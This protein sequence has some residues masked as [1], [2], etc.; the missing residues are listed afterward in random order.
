MK[1][2]SQG[3]LVQNT[4]KLCSSGRAGTSS[5]KK[6]RTRCRTRARA[7]FR[8]SRPFVSASRRGAG[9]LLGL[10]WSNAGVRDGMFLYFAAW[11]T[12]MM[13]EKLR[14]SWRKSDLSEMTGDGEYRWKSVSLFASELVAWLIDEATHATRAHH[15]FRRAREAEE[16]EEEAEEPFSVDAAHLVSMMQEY[17]RT[18]EKNFELLGQRTPAPTSSSSR[19]IASSPTPAHWPVCGAASAGGSFCCAPSGR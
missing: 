16:A 19:W 15:Q 18:R 14:E 10:L 6:G 17:E 9:G 2:S 5:I 3:G 12:F 8:T 1:G 7:T 13:H 11:P 4:R